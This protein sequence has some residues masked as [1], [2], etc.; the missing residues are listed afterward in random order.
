M[1]P[2]GAGPGARKRAGDRVFMATLLAAGL[3]VIGLACAMAG[4]LVAHSRLAWSTFGPRFLWTSTWDPVQEVFGA[5]PFIYGTLV[6]SALALAIAAPLGLGA[7]IFLAEVAPRRLSSALSFGIELLAAVP[8]VVLGLIGVFVLVPAVRAVEPSLVRGFGWLPLFRGA[9]YGVGM[10]TAG[11]LLAFIILPYITSISREVIL[12]VPV[13]LR[14]AA[15]G[16]GATHW[17]TV[18][19]VVLPGAW[20]GI[21]GAVFLALGRALGETMAVTM[22]IGNTPQVS[23]S[24]LDPGYTMAAVLANEFTEATS[25]L[26]L[27]ALVAVALTLFG[28]TIVVNGLARLMIHRMRAR[29]TGA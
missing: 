14:E 1:R 7:A 3:T 25:D 23:S 15:L 22:V 5:W 2:D 13:S 8:T 16:L 9:P 6:S 28:I 27:H 12:T 17:E 29:W 18:R 26:Y 19:L 24:L 20:S 11:I 4:I 21:V 10:L